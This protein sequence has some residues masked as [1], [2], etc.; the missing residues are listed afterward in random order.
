LKEIIKKINEWKSEQIEL[1]KLPL[2]DKDIQIIEAKMKAYNDCIALLSTYDLNKLSDGYHTFEELYF[3][4]MILFSV[5]CKQNKDKSWRSLL[6]NDGTMFKDYFIVGIETEKGQYTYHYHI[7]HFHHFA[8]VKILD[9][10]PS[11][12]GHKPEDVIRLK[13]LKLS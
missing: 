3:H 5:V 2:E 1:L 4:R 12:D 8:G 11:W 9:K 10:A 6:H 13:D 7:N